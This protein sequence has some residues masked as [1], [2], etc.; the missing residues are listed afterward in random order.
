MASQAPLPLVQLPEFYLH[1]ILLM[2]QKSDFDGQFGLQSPI[3]SG[4][5]PAG[6]L[7]YIVVVQCFNWLG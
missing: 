6:L 2:A 7:H 3:N 1:R 5:S 4:G